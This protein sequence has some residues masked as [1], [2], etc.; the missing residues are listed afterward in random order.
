MEV[1]ANTCIQLQNPTFAD[2]RS[3]ISGMKQLIDLRGGPKQLMKESPHLV[4]SV[5]LY[6][7]YARFPVW[8][9]AQ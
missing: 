8:S 6:L 5:V 3:H 2:W 7:M 9:Q 1:R 4:A